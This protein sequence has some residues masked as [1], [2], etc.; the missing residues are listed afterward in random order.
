[1][2]EVTKSADNNQINIDIF[3]ITASDTYWVAVDNSG[4][5]LNNSWLGSGITGLPHDINGNTIDKID[6]Q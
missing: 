2:K 3:N 1:M 4:I 6:L 5:K